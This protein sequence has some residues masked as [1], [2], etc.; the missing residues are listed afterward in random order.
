MK[1]ELSVLLIDGEEQSAAPVREILEKSKSPSMQVQW[2][3]TL[4]RAV[5][6]LDGTAFDAIVVHLELPDSKGFDTFARLKQHQAAAALLVV[7]T[8]EDDELALRTLRAGAEECLTRDEVRAPDLARRLRYA[9]ERHWSR[10]PHEARVLAFIGAQGGV[11]T[12]TVALNMAAAMLGMGKSVIAIEMH[13]DWGSFSTQLILTPARTIRRLIE[14]A[15][16]SAAEVQEALFKLP[17]GMQ[18]LFGPQT[19]EEFSAEINA[20]KALMILKGAASLAD[21]VILDLPPGPSAANAALVHA[22]NYSV[23]VLERERAAFESA[24]AHLPMVESWSAAQ[25]TVGALVV[26]RIS[27][28]ESVGLD[29]ITKRL[30]CGFLG[31]VPPAAE[32]LAVRGTGIPLALARPDLAFSHSVMQIAERLSVD[33]VKYFEV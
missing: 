1:N 26:N 17:S 2:A 24:V 22:A 16:V 28:V 32:V 15:K 21:V 33:P 10:M 4:A 7:M 23:L 30:S 29:E 3:G 8:A 25:R 13:P 20:E 9:V 31:T 11:G 12:T 18:V 27:F 19:V 14:S 5:E 6:L